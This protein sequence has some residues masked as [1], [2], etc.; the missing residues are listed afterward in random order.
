MKPAAIFDG[1]EYDAREPLGHDCA[2]KLGIPE[3]NT[4]FNGEILPSDGAEVYLRKDLTMSAVNAYVWSRTEGSCEGEHGKVI[5]DRSYSS[6]QK[7]TLMPGE[8]LVVDFGQNCAGVPFFV[9]K[10]DAGT[11]LTCLPSELLN[12]GNGSIARGMDGPEGSCHRENL[13]TPD[14]GMKIEYT[15]G[16]DGYVHYHPTCSFFGY[17]Y[18]SMTATGKV[19]IISI[20]SVPVTSIA[21]NLET[22]RISTGNELINRLISNTYWGQLSNYLSVPTDCPQRN[23]RLGWAADT[24]VFAETGTFFADTRSFFRKWMRDMR[25]SQSP[26]GAYPAVAPFAY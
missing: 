13:R 19:T 22:G 15:F 18:V 11:R 17:R 21:E 12:D 4:E 24:Q 3:I 20:E 8:T 10:A 9:F 7:M 23:E 6:G 16:S 26:T 25:D 1:E 2:E 14:I 5:I